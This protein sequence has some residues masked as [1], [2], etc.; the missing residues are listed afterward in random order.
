MFSDVL[1]TARDHLAP[2]MSVV[3]TVE[4]T[5]EGDEL[6]LLAKAAQPIDAAVAGAASAGL[7]VFLDSAAAAPSLA[8]R[9]AAIARDSTAR[10]RGPVNLILMHPD[11]PGEV[12]VALPDPYPM[13][14]QVMGALKTVPGVVHIEEF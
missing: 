7:R 11:L 13:S 1:D 5:L 2:G 10:R 6:K 8:T 3:L 9:L 14:P 4:A 12:E